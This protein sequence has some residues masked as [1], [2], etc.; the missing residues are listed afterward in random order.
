MSMAATAPMT[1]IN[2]YS[3][4]DVAQR[5]D[6]SDETV[7]EWIIAK[8]LRASKINKRVLIRHAELE[9]LL[10]RHEL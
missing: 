7:R 8:K 9:S 6:V 3:I 5:L 1:P 4:A 10:A 2:C